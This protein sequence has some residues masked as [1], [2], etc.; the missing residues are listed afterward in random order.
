M[1][2]SS[3]ESSLSWQCPHGPCGCCGS[4][5]GLWGPEGPDTAPA[6]PKVHQSLQET[7][8][9]FKVT[10]EEL[11][12]RGT[13]G[14]QDVAACDTA[15][16]V[17]D[18]TGRHCQISAPCCALLVPSLLVQGPAVGHTQDMLGTDVLVPVQPPSCSADVPV[19]AVLGPP[20]C[21][22]PAV[23][24]TGPCPPTQELLL[25]M[26]G[27]GFPWS[28]LLLVLLVLAAGFLLHD[29]QTHGSF[30][31]RL[32][33]QSDPGWENPLGASGKATTIPCHHNCRIHTALNPPRDGNST[34]IL[35]SLDSSVCG[36][37]GFCLQSK[38]CLS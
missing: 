17:R 26:K 1:S 22:D 21:Q 14:D 5:G 32:G 12:A 25:K 24:V 15:C 16:K 33:N 28:R 11:A 31:G 29:V 34:I 36:K 38:P 18:R 20:R 10:N 4:S 9:S 13:G 19:P 2:P 6:V 30:Q 8:R 7:V 23:T 37:T 3:S 27:R 35:G